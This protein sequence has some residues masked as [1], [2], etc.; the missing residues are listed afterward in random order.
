MLSWEE[1]EALKN[2]DSVFG[3]VNFAVKKLSSNNVSYAK[4]DM[5]LEYVLSKLQTLDCNLSNE[6]LKYFKQHI[7]ERR[8]TKVATMLSFLNDQ[9][10]WKL[11]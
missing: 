2:I 7:E 5:V 11:Y 8:N 4:C 10:I 3:I 9:V 1:M 6:F